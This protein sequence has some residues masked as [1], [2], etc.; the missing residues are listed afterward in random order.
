M[1]TGRTVPFYPPRSPET[2]KLANSRQSQ[3]LQNINILLTYP[4]CDDIF[5]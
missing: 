2:S 4:D 5:D 3:I 1:V